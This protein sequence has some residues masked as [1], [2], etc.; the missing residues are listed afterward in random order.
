LKITNLDNKNYIVI[1]EV[2]AFLSSDEENGEGIIAMEFF[3]DGRLMLMPFITADK[4]RLES[5]RPHAEEM[6][7]DSNNKIKL[8]KFTQ[9]IDIEEIN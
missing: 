2:Y 6:A 9:R 7:K 4:A 1:D 5:F 3:M 8:V